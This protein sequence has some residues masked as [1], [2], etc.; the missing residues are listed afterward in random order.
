MR[1]L[2]EN[3][4][5]FVVTR[6]VFMIREFACVSMM[7]YDQTVFEMMDYVFMT[8]QFDECVVFMMRIVYVC[9]E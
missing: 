1:Q 6:L 4:G 9:I 2:Y 7:F 5:A 3:V 8:K